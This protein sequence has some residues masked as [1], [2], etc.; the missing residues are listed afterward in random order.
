MH[1][2]YFLRVA[3]SRAMYF[4]ARSCTAKRK[5]FTLDHGLSIKTVKLVDTCAKMLGILTGRLVISKTQKQYRKCFSLLFLVRLIQLGPVMRITQDRQ[6]YSS[7][8]IP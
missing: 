4:H 5:M 8:N 3:S 7:C 1:F 2:L 6:K